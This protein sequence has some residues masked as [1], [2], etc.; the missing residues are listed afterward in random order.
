[1]SSDHKDN[2]SDSSSG[3]QDNIEEE[4]ER[5]KQLWFDAYEEWST[6][7]PDWT[8]FVN[9]PGDTSLW[10]LQWHIVTRG[11]S[12][13]DMSHG[14][15]PLHRAAFAR[16][17]DCVRYLIEQKADLEGK[18]IDYHN[19]ALQEATRANSLPCMRILLEAKADPD[20]HRAGALTPLMY[21]ASN[22]LLA[23]ARLLLEA[24]AKVD[25]SEAGV[26]D[27][28][29]VL[30]M[31]RLGTPS[32]TALEWAKEEEDHDMVAL[33]KSVQDL[34][35]STENHKRFPVQGK[36]AVAALM[37]LHRT[38]LASAGKGRNKRLKSYH[39]DPKN[40]FW[41]LPKP[42][43]F[44]ILTLALGKARYVPPQELL[45]VS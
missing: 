7:C 5:L 18:D 42:L 33:L 8:T 38:E 37:I 3:E 31:Q 24:G 19:T 11:L 40:R 34:E 35:W 45:F 27:I 22:R 1:M 25:I 39:P 43:L 23:Q 26:S 10:F 29:V 14:V 9:M 17:E 16:R 28:T 44:R 15:P 21:C 36:S 2:K 12:V 30:W 32:R 13:N 41:K 20:G 6:N 4:K